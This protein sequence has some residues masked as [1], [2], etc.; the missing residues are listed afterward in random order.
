MKI[1]LVHNYYGSGAP[2]GENNVFEL[3]RALLEQRGHP[4]EVLTRHSDDLRRRGL[5]GMI[6][7]AL[8]TPW[9]PVSA[10]AV[11]R[12]VAECRPDVVHAHNTFPLLS[13]A[14]FPAIGSRAA[15]VLTLHNYRL[16]CP[17]A[18]PQRDGNSCTECLDGRSVAPAL[19]HGCYRGSRVATLPLAASVALHRWGGTWR[20]HVDAFIALTEFQRNVMI[21]AGLPQ[22]RVFVKPNFYPGQPRVVPWPERSDRVV[23]AGRL[24]P[25]KGV[26]TL[27]DAWIAW[28]D[29]APE[30][31]IV[32]DGPL[33]ERLQR[34]ARER[35]C[36]V[37]FLGQV[38]A[39]AA[40]AE[41]AAARLLV[42]PSV[43]FEGFPLVLREAFA[44]GTPAAVSGIGPLPHIVQHGRTGVVFRPGDPG[45]LLDSVRSA[46]H[47]TGQLRSMSEQA[48]AEFEEKYAEGANY[49]ALMDIYD[50][51]VAVQKERARA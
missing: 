43:S 36:R 30:L 14:I 22:E 33:R 18:I 9:S 27:L 35:R 48:R 2:S 49:R 25:E 5:V 20:H 10:R 28:G 23:F 11:R 13:P 1:L 39:A 19:R 47:R 44:F 38:T 37:R 46:W 24:S 45:S 29:T 15:R 6:V 41:I 32:G 50:R 12:I 26:A 40:E 21:D 8:A 3:E 4:V 42:V 16:F 7:G 51:A 17:S 31:C 34:R